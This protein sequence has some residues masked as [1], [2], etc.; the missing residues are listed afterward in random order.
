MEVVE[1]MTKR[2][3][4]LFLHPD[5]KFHMD[6]C[7]STRSYLLRNPKNNQCHPLELFLIADSI[8]TGH[9][10]GDLSKLLNKN[11]R[12]ILGFYHGYAGENSKYK[13]NSYQEGFGI[14]KGVR[15][16]ITY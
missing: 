14:G 11:I 3:Q 5:N 12:W 15:T 4:L 8:F 16:K 9:K 2:A 7:K 13:N 1:E 10:I 6:F